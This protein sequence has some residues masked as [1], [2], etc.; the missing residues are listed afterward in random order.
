[1]QS[2]SEKK[3]KLV[4]RIGIHFE[5]KMSITPLAARILGL[6][7]LSPTEDLTFDDITKITCASKSSISTNINLLLQ[8]KSIEYFTKPG[9]RKRYFRASKNHLEIALNDTLDKVKADLE[10]IDLIDKFNKISEKEKELEH[11]HQVR[12]L[13]KEYLNNQQNNLKKT[14]EKIS[15][16]QR[17]Q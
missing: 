10:I 6:L 15:E 11:K 5:K 12:L 7:I 4:E 13:Y 3:Q 8:L 9:D 17:T 1:M 16:I 2:C 14:I